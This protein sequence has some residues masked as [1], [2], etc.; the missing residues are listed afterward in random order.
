MS[1]TVQSPRPAPAAPTSN[2]PPLAP[3]VDFAQLQPGAKFV[4]PECPFCDGRHAAVVTTFEDHVACRNR[5]P[6]RWARFSVTGAGT[7]RCRDLG[8]AECEIQKQRAT[9]KVFQASA[10]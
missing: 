4:I 1:R 2:P 10:S 9:P 8:F 6:C 7:P 5:K 3:L